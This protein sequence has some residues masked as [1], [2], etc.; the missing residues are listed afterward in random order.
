MNQIISLPPTKFKARDIDRETIARFLELLTDAP[1]SGVCWRFLPDS[2][3]AKAY[4]ATFDPAKNREGRLYEVED[5]MGDF[6]SD[7]YGAF[8][9]VNA[10]GQRG[11]DIKTVRALYIDADDI[12]LPTE[13]HAPPD[14]LVKR[15]P[16]RWHAYWKVSDCPLD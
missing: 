6:Q 12:P 15:S 13:W 9:V 5:D 7:E 16:T 14:F 2:K 10:G 11:E 8:V 1:D 4:D 3:K